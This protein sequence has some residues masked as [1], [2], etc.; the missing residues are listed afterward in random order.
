M[1]P[2]SAGRARP[3]A[4]LFFTPAADSESGS[5]WQSTVV[6]VISCRPPDPASG[7]RRPSRRGPDPALLGIQMAL[8][9][10]ECL[11]SALAIA[12]GIVVMLVALRLCDKHGTVGSVGRGMKEDLFTDN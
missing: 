11:S 9:F 8:R 6:L 7:C 12:F 10:S 4:S 1:H 3:A 2:S 5:D